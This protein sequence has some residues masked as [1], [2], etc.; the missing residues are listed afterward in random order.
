MK[1]ITLRLYTTK[2]DEDHLARI[3]RISAHIHNELVSYCT[4]QIR[5][6]ERSK[7]YRAAVESRDWKTVETIRKQFP[8]DRNALYA[9]VKVMQHRYKASIGAHMAQDIVDRVLAGL[10]RYFYGDGHTLHF[11]RQRELTTVA[12][13]STAH[14][15]YDGTQDRVRI[16]SRRYIRVAEPSEYQAL[17]LM[18]SDIRFC[19]IKRMIFDDGWHY[20]L[21]ICVDDHYEVPDSD[22]LIGVDIGTSTVAVVSD[23]KADIHVLAPYVSRYNKRIV[24]LQRQLDES[25]RMFNPDAYNPDGTSKRGVK[26]KHSAHGRYL[27]RKIATL[28]RQKAA[29]IRQSHREYIKTLGEG[30]I[31]IED[32]DFRALAKRS[33]K[34]TERQN[35]E[36]IVNGKAVHKC[37]RKKRF[38]TSMNNR[39]PGELVE[40]LYDHHKVIKL[41]TFDTRLSKLNHATGE[42]EQTSLGTRSKMIDGNWVQRDMYSAFLIQH[43]A[44]GVTDI[45]G[46]AHDFDA[47]LEHQNQ[48]V[49]RII[50]NNE[51]TLKSFGF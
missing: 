8:F 43:T 10:N 19:R 39:A 47:Y 17:Q 30:T 27:L 49:H 22:K 14:I 13:K 5:E 6:L 2:Q 41:S 32:M 36:S 15:K 38:G 33:T 28:D 40:L 12:S 46:C 18:N 26:R 44:N 31:V 29:Y 1:N 9:Y 34:P 7:S 21:Q 16:L 35:K 50:A 23:D 45:T 20:Y 24:K 48:A 25:D 3:Y 42:Y 37:K 51:A 4:G 11:L